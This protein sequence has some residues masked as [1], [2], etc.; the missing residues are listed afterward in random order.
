MHLSSLEC[1][2]VIESTASTHKPSADG[3]CPASINVVVP[4]YNAEEH[5][6]GLQASIDRQGIAPANIL[7][8]DSSS[9]DRTPELARS[10]G[11]RVLSIPKEEFGH[12]LTRQVAC[13]LLPD[14][15]LLVYLTQDA[16]LDQPDAISTLCAA[17]DDPSTGAAYG[18]QVARPAADPIERHARLFNYPEHSHVR[19]F[20]SRREHGIKSAFCSN[21][22]AVYRRSALLS[23]GGFPAHVILGEDSVVAARLLMAGW[24]VI[25]AADAIA[26]HS[27]PLRLRQEFGRYFDTGV[28]HA[29]ERWLLQTFGSASSEGRSFVVSETR[30]LLR[31]AP[32]MVPMGLVRTWNKLVAYRLGRLERFLP[33][34]VL[35]SLS[36]HP[37]FWSKQ[38]R[39][40]P[41]LAAA[42]PS[43]SAGTITPASSLTVGAAGQ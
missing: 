32:L 36:A 34:S 31:H 7:I 6:P 29:R 5:W 41:E 33:L 43:A 10:S 39:K 17:L 12:G 30:Y 38:E 13:D 1:G 27:H 16:L 18:R 8:V 9:S 14:A 40:L 24:Q 3:S 19:T 4:T 23:V 28:H 35:R 25:Y 11:Y 15:D 42:T 37:G 22:F 20:E 26:V 21:S 2:V